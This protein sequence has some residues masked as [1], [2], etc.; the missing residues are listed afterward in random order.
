MSLFSS[1]FK[2]SPPRSVEVRPIGRKLS[3]GSGETLLERALKDGLAYPHDCTVGTCGT[4]RTKLI[5]GKVDAITPF[6][7]TLSREELDAGYILACQAIP[8]SDLVVEV[9]IASQANIAATTQKARLLGTDDLTH[10]I[11]RVRW[12]VETPLHYRA[13][14]YANVRWGADAHRSYSFA[15]APAAGGMT[16]LTS[17]IRHVPGGTFTDILFTGDAAALNYEIDG[18]HGNFWL[19]DGTGPII[20]IAGGSG[21]API[22]SLLQDAANRKVRRDCILLFGARGVADIYAADEIAAIR[23]KWMGGF[24]YWPV[25]SEESAAGYRH[26]MVTAHLSEALTRL[27]AGVQAYLCGPP[28]MVDAGIKGLTG[29]GV[30]LAEVHY[31]KFT[32]ASSKS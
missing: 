1:L 24:D 13:G 26:G 18:P 9:E 22:V 25:L 14:Q 15:A 7:Y 20:C 6:S 16:E 30:A 12:S 21:L 3:V 8:K 28:G 19:R 17:F 5:S 29:A 2:K 31:D 23:N 10:D 11:K 4:C 32:D 27:G